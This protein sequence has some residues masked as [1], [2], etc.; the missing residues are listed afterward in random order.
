MR[1]PWITYTALM[2]SLLL[3]ACTGGGASV[4]LAAAM[5]KWWEKDG[6]R[7]RLM[8]IAHVD[9]DKY[10][11]VNQRFGHRVGDRLLDG[12]AQLIKSL[13]REDRGYDV[14]TQV[15]GQA[16]VLMFGDT[17]PRNATSAA[18]RI[19]QTI[20]ATTFEAKGTSIEVTI[21]TGVAECMTDDSLDAL[22]AKAKQAVKDA[23]NNGRNRTSL[24]EGDGPKVMDPPQ[25]Q[26]QDRVIQV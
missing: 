20:E 5:N 8:S 1:N 9:V 12:F 16:F 11:G 24:D 15:S 6:G 13:I 10:S 4:G 18:E 3:G 7:S 25:Y 19:R 26:V 21:S 22:L 17:G 23:K 14:A 2:F